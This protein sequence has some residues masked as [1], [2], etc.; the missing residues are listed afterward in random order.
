MGTRSLTIVAEKESGK[1]CLVMYRQMDGYPSGHGRELWQKFG[2]H[3][4]VNGFSSQTSAEYAN[5]MGCLAAQIVAAFKD[6]IG[7]F[8]LYPS[9]TRNCGEEYIYYLYPNTADESI[10][11]LKV[12]EVGWKSGRKTLYEGTLED[13]AGYLIEKEGC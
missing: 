8:Y 6:G 4:L 10:I 5:G 1:E 11:N 7:N 2:R 9:R 12:I 13:F 3:K